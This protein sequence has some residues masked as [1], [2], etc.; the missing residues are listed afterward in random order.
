MD[1]YGPSTYGDRFADV[2]D[3]WSGDVGDPQ[4]ASRAVHELS[5]GGAVLELGVGSGRLAIPL[6]AAGCEVW[7]IE[8]SPAML[9][10]LASRPGAEHVRAV[11]G[12]MADPA[13]ALHGA[14]APRFAAVVAAFNTFFLLADEG[15]QARCLRSIVPLL[16]PGG[17]VL[18]ECFV[19]GE[20]P[21]GVERI[22]EPR[23]VAVDHVVLTCTEHDPVTQVVR[24]QHVE[25]RESGTRLRPWVLRYATPA[26]LDE[27]ATAAGLDL[28]ARWSG[29]DRER[30]NPAD[31]MHVSV[32][33]PR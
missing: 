12:D 15:A 5:G 3:D 10:V 21:P 17:V 13:A 24:G 14:G 28:V 11:L 18:L 30:P 29:W 26:Q 16:A 23:T 4:A 7:G 2:Y 31:A 1:G 20:P 19:P 27:L 6:A 25:L 22:V 9:D 33:G 8:S 32:Y